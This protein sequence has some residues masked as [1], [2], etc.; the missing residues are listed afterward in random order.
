M[1]CFSVVMWWLGDLLGIEGY[2]QRGVVYIGVRDIFEGMGIIYVLGFF[3]LL[4]FQEIG[5]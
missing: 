2:F 3:G 1:F 4:D 5:V